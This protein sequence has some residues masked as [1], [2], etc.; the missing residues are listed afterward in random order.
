VIEQKVQRLQ[1]MIENIFRSASRLM[2]A[3]CD[4]VELTPSQ[5]FVLRTLETDGQMTVSDL[6][7]IT[8]GAQSTASEMVARLVK[9]GY[10]HKK[11]SPDDG[12]AVTIA[13]TAN[14]KAI[15][16]ARLESMLRRHRTVLAA[17]TTTDQERMLNAFE[18]IV[19]LMDRAAG[20]AA[21]GDNDEK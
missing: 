10:V 4:D 8:N 14:G 6:R 18:T 21:H 19:E 9:Q 16:R 2:R 1:E 5:T 7:R 3:D 15:L 20:N 17:L 13:I 11:P 12:R